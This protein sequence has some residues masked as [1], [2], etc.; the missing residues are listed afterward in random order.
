MFM[1][2]VKDYVSQIHYNACILSSVPDD[3]T[4]L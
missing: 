2:A 1:W 4:G 3:K